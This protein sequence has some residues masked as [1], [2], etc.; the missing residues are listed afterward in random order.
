MA[1]DTT[2]PDPL[3]VQ[4][5]LSLQMG[6]WQQLGKIASPVSGQVDRDLAMAKVSID[7]LGMIQ[8]KTAGNLNPEEKRM[9]DHVLYELRLNYVDELKKGE[10][11]P[12]AG[13]GGADDAG[14]KPEDQ[15]GGETAG[16]GKSD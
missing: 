1:E 6:A 13:T 7:L 2:T 10:T 8:A 9:L 4:L 12:D 5:V 11:R 15:P 16:S 3:F 14:R